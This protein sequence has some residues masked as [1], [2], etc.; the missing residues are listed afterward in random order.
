MANGGHARVDQEQAFQ[1][2]ASLPHDARS[3]AAVAGYFG[4]S[5]RTVERYARDGRWKERRRRIQADAAE[6]ADRELGRDLASQL[7]DFHHL[8][9]ASCVTYARQLASGEVRISAAEFVGLVKVAL[10]LQGG[11]TARIDTVT[12]TAEWAGLRDRIL[13]AV[14]PYP[15][16]RLALAVAL[17]PEEEIDDEQTRG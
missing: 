13:Q 10:L 7:A 3:Y 12:D 5:P 14:E 15:E 6:R 17:G 2:W 8:I 1:F 4:V 9:E 11:P 16:V